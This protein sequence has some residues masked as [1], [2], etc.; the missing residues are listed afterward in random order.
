MSKIDAQV[1]MDTEVLE[2]VDA[3]AAA[4]GSTREQVIENSVRRSLAALALGEV[5][6][7]V[8]ARSADGL[9]EA[10]ASDLAYSEV[11]AARADRMTA[12]RGGAAG[13]LVG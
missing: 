11:K 9:S 4:L 8:R 10:Q 6:R 12:T 7:Q 3:L 5:L 13:P 1:Q 2:R